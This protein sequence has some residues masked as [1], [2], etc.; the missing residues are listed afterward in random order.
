MYPNIT[1]YKIFYEGLTSSELTDRRAYMSVQKIRWFLQDHKNE[2][3][4]VGIMTGI[5]LAIAF[6]ATGDISEAIARSR[7]R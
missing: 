7:K 6:A 4:V 1:E 5:S 3:L 2:L